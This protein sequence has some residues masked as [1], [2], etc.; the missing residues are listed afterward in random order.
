MKKLSIAKLK[1][2]SGAIYFSIATLCG[3]Y[4]CLLILLY[5]LGIDFDNRP[6]CSRLSFDEIV[7]VANAIESFLLQGL[8]VFLVLGGIISLIITIINQ[9]TNANYYDEKNLQQ[10]FFAIMLLAVCLLWF[11]F[12]YWKAGTFVSL[13]CTRALTFKTLEVQLRVIINSLFLFVLPTSF[14]GACAWVFW[15]EVF[16]LY[17]P[18]S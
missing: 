1:N 2:L 17:H 11:A 3:L 14:L 7:P 4:P 16:E 8:A 9:R 10:A 5:T 15:H 13:N 18:D 6:I 12:L